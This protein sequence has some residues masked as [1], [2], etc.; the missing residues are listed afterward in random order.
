[1]K[2]K[3]SQKDVE[4]GL[5]GFQCKK[6]T[7]LRDEQLKELEDKLSEAKIG[8]RWSNIEEMSF[9]VVQCAEMNLDD[10]AKLS[11]CEILNS[12]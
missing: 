1:M 2:N 3:I 11:V 4:W 7:S 8:V 10:K 9:L 5:Y 6:I 12:L